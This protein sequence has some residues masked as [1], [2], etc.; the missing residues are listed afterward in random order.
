[1]LIGARRCT[2]KPVGTSRWIWRR[3]AR[4]FW[5]VRESCQTRLVRAIWTPQPMSTP[6]AYGTTAPSAKST[7]PIGM[8]KPECASGIS[9]A[10]SIAIS[11]FPTLCAWRSA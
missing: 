5:G 8:P 7:P 6:M 4:S 3:T 9:A 11:R 2:A 1:M 10:W